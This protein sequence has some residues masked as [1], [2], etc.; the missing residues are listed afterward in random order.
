MLRWFLT[1]QTHDAQGPCA[2]PCGH[3]VAPP[4]GPAGGGGGGGAGEG[5]S[6]SVPA[7][8]MPHTGDAGPGRA[9]DILDG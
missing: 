4:G 5:V 3:G 2:Q 1:G 7:G 9:D 8:A 6:K